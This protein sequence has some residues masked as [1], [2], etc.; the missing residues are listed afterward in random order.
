MDETL[1]SF[2]YIFNLRHHVKDA[3]ERSKAAVAEAQ[4]GA[5]TR[6]LFSST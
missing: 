5:Y 6:S 1:S 4:A 3:K 2:A